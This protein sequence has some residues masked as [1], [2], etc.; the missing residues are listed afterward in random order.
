MRSMF[1]E[2]ISPR[3]R[4]HWDTLDFIE[5]LNQKIRGLKNYYKISVMAVRWLTKIDWYIRKLL[6]LHYNKRRNNGNKMSNW[7]TVVRLIEGKLLRL[8]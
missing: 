1:K 2:Y 4:L 3:N 7:I 5:G 6:I 8:A